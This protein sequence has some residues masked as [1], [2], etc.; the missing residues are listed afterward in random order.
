M[1]KKYRKEQRRKREHKKS[2]LGDVGGVTR[3]YADLFN[4]TGGERMGDRYYI[5]GV[6]LG[7]L[8]S[9]IRFRRENDA[10]R[11][12]NEIEKNQF[13]LR[14]GVGKEPEEEPKEDAEIPRIGKFDFK[15]ALTG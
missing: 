2:F 10:I 4:G 12:L 5:T 3:R 14:K 8:I 9:S 15:K 1:T 7:M 11:L 13:L 6:Q